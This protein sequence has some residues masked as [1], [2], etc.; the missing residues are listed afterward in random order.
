[1]NCEGLLPDRFI[2]N[3]VARAFASD[4]TIAIFRN[5]SKRIPSLAKQIS[6]NDIFKTEDWRSV[7]L[8]PD[9]TGATEK[10]DKAPQALSVQLRTSAPF[11]HLS[12]R[13]ST[14]IDIVFGKDNTATPTPIRSKALPVSSSA[15]AI[16]ASPAS[17]Q[18][19]LPPKPS[20][21]SAY[22]SEAM[23]KASEAMESLSFVDAII[24]PTL[25]W[26]KLSDPNRL[27]VYAASKKL[28]RQMRHSEQLLVERYPDL[29][30][31]LQHPLGLG[32]PSNRCNLGRTL[33]L[34][35]IYRGWKAGDP[36]T[37][38][39]RCF[40]CQTAFVPRFIVTTSRMGGELDSELWCELLSPW[41]FRK[42]VYTA[43]FQDGIEDM[44]SLNYRSSSSQ[45][46]VVF[47]N[48][49][50][51]FRLIG[52]PYSFLLSEGDYEVAFPSH[53]AAADGNKSK[54]VA[55]K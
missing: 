32:C 5:Q 55:G 3:A 19:P 42:E 34:Q 25:Q 15:S 37:Y 24:F 45:R 52:L 29:S 21:S 12:S 44:L 33:T 11:L 35:E 1:M 6:T 48:L 7:R 43:L 20:T 49:I 39:T 16:S 30:I 31:N 26:S 4:S 22:L 28:H 23:N 51:A 17:N 14:L 13:S 40:N 47:W 41:T 53:P 8:Y 27:P 18:P 2:L 9:A 54:Q 10:K 46:A 36:N 38:T 50:V